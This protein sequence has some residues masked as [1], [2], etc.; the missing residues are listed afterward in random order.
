MNSKP[1]FMLV[2]KVFT[3]YERETILTGNTL[4]SYAAHLISFIFSPK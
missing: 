4:E 3:L 1:E 2:Y